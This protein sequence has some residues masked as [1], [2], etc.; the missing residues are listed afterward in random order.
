MT[1]R[2]TEAGGVSQI[3]KVQRA[4]TVADA[5][6]GTIQSFTGLTFALPE[7]TAV[8]REIW[9]SWGDGEWTKTSAGGYGKL[10]TLGGQHRYRAPGTYT[11]SAKVYGVTIQ[12]F[13]VVAA[14][15]LT[16]L[17]TASLYSASSEPFAPLKTSVFSLTDFAISRAQF[18]GSV[19]N[20]GDGVEDYSY[21]ARNQDGTISSST[22]APHQFDETS[23]LSKPVVVLNSPDRTRIIPIPVERVAEPKAADLFLYQDFVSA[24]DPILESVFHFT[25]DTAAYEGQILSFELLY[26]DGQTTGTV[27]TDSLQSGLA[28]VPFQLPTHLAGARFRVKTTFLGEEY[29]SGL[30]EVVPGLAARQDWTAEFGGVKRSLYENGVGIPASLTLGQDVW[31]TVEVRDAYENMQPDG[32][33]L[34]WDDFGLV[35]PKAISISNPDSAMVSKLQKG[36]ASFGLRNSD[37]TLYLNLAARVDDLEQNRLVI[38]TKIDRVVI[39]RSNGEFYREFPQPITITARAYDVYGAL[40]PSGVPIVFAD[41]RGVIQNGSTT[42]VNGVATTQFALSQTQIDTRI[43]GRAFVVA[44][45]AGV[46]SKPNDVFTAIDIHKSPTEYYYSD[47]LVVDHRVLSIEDNKLRTVEVPRADASD[48]QVQQFS[49]TA[50]HANTL[51]PSRSYRIT[52]EGVRGNGIYLS[53]SGPIPRS[54]TRPTS[55]AIPAGSS[56]YDVMLYSDGSDIASEQGMQ[57]VRLKLQDWNVFQFGWQEVESVASWQDVIVGQRDVA[58]S[59][60]IGVGLVGDFLWGALAGSDNLDAGL[61]GDMTI[62]LK[63]T[64]H[65]RGTKRRCATLSG[66]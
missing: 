7:R 12:Q 15:E 27:K 4:V 10:Y 17:D 24:D 23:T 25:G 14:G 65:Y 49:S 32:T 45:V 58:T 21:V 5:V 33:L 35:N 52:I 34:A 48:L 62:E 66:G 2:V 28:G 20:W 38:G 43:S 44:T 16:V 13:I 50:V 53:N 18:S 11:M 59:Y 9:I 46:K 19:I 51:A 47:I 39:T 41:S 3:R 40:L 36:R 64:H 6:V 60:E 56:S 54:Q 30:G 8:P 61:A 29:F 26:S 55:I 42:L 22:V 1:V 37:K 57:K 63:G 31:V